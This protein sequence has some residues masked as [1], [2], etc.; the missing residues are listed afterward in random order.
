[1]DKKII[2]GVLA[3]VVVSISSLLWLPESPK[4]SPDTLP[5]NIKHPTPQTSHIFGITL[6]ESTLAD[7]EQVFKEQTEI[8]LFKTSEGKM[9]VEAFFDELN[10]N[11]LK[12]KFVL[13]M[14]VPA[15]KLSGMFNRGLRMNSTPSG[16]RITLTADDLIEVRKSPVASF[17][18]LPSVK[19]S[20]SVLAKRF[21]EPAQ[22]IQEANGHVVHWLYP[23]HGLDIT[24]ADGEKPVL[25]YIQPKDFELLRA[26]L[27]VQMKT[28][29]TK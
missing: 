23:Q 18:Y 21:G 29:P 25:Q 22:R 28:D 20:E 7:L 27:L 10:L 13:T 17:T 8:S 4:D 3:L 1:M 19:L 12:A 11:G 9:L 6:G 24:L 14:A 26:P 2:F 16:K 5:W 15:E